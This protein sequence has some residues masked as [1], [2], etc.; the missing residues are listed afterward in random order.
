MMEKKMQALES[1]IAEMS[2]G[3]ADLV[4]AANEGQKSAD[5]IASTLADMCKALEASKSGAGLDSVVAAIKAIRL[6]PTIN[7]S[8]TPIN[9]LPAEIRFVPA[10]TEHF[11]LDLQVKYD[12]FDRIESARIR[13]IPVSKEK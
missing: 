7:V 9:V 11:E 12:K 10:P 5:E 13:R 8:P 4:S 2:A 6:D 1:L 3:M